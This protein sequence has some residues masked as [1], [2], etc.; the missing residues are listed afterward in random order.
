MNRTKHWEDIYE[1][2]QL[3]EVSWYQSKPQTSLELIQ[4]LAKNKNANI[5]DVGGGDGLLVDHLL[6]QGFQNI[7]VLDISSKAIDRAKTRLGKMANQVKWIVS[8]VVNFKPNEK[9]DIW[10][11]RA[12]FHFLTDSNDIKH[13]VKNAHSALKPDGKM[14][15]GTFSTNGPTKC[16]GIEIQQFDEESMK[17]TFGQ[18]FRSIDFSIHQHETPSKKIQEFIFGRFERI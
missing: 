14:I 6:K 5:I 18:G 4:G 17:H 9:Y 1:S 16:S 7:T 15:V 12:A 13:Y 8:D 3:N 2:K 11:D 10:H